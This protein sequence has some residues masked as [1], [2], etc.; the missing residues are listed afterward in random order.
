M[1]DTSDTVGYINV[2]EIEHDTA[3]IIAV[4][5]RDFTGNQKISDQE[6]VAFQRT[7]DGF[8][9]VQD[10]EV[11]QN[12]IARAKT[13]WFMTEATVVTTEHQPYSEIVEGIEQW[14]VELN[15][16][17]IVVIEPCGIVEHEDDV[18]QLSVAQPGP[19]LYLTVIL[20]LIDAGPSSVMFREIDMNDEEL[21]ADL[22]DCFLLESGIISMDP[23][24]TDDEVDEDTDDYDEC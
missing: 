15:E 22:I 19:G 4:C 24:E 1:S 10:T 3:G 11:V 16:Y 9:A 8:K 23:T 12:A 14:S 7:T 17:G 5:V 13:Y 21:Q 6:F 18:Y 20:R 2:Y